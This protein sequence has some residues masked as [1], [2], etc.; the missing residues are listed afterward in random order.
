M[1][2]QTMRRF[3][4][5]TPVLLIVLVLSILRWGGYLLI[6][7]DEIPAGSDAAVVLQ[8][9][10][11]GE[12]VRIPGAIRLLQDGGASRVLLSIDNAT[13]WGERIP[14]LAR[15]FL[16]TRYGDEIASRIDFCETGPE[17]NSTAD[18][19]RALT[20]CMRARGWRSIVVVTSNYHTRRAG[21]IWRRVIREQKLPVKLSM[22][23]V[24]D[25]EFTPAGWWRQRQ[26]AKTWLLETTKLLWTIFVPGGS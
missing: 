23:G 15:R 11:V 2:S 1:I 8:G 13:V 5:M 14:P 12:S 3:L 16:Q 25:P 22:E 9:S 7:G 6:A 17:V 10:Y 21:I 4:W 26:Y 19:A 20:E 18:E 24:E